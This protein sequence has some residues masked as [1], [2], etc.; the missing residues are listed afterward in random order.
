MSAEG[1][2][3]ARGG[4]GPR[5][6]RRGWAEEL[7]WALGSPEEPAGEGFLRVQTRYEGLCCP[8]GEGTAAGC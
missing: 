8:P 2:P 7:G 4:A 3:R 5:A 6:G 1:R